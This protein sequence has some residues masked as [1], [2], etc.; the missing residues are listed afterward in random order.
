MNAWKVNFRLAARK[1]MLFCVAAVLVFPWP[2]SQAQTQTLFSAGITNNI[3]PVD[4]MLVLRLANARNLDIQIA[5]RRIGEAQAN[6]E[7][8][9]ERFF[10]WLAPGAV[11]QRHGDLAQNVDGT[12]IDA[13]KQLYTLGGALTAQ[14]ELGDA[15]YSSL[16]AKQR[17][18]AADHGLDSQR[19]DSV[20]SAAQGYYELVKASA[21]VE[22][23]REALNISEDYQQQLHD[24]VDTGIAFKGDELRVQVQTER[25]QIVLQQTLEQ[26]RVAAARLAEVL[27]LDANVELVPQ[28]ADLVP[29]ALVET[30]ATLEALTRQALMARPELKQDR[31]LVAA[32]HEE[33]NSALYG[34]LIPSLN[35]QAF[36]GGLGGGQNGSTGNFGGTED[37]YFGLGWRIGPGGLF[38]FGRIHASKARLEIS[39]LNAAKT[40]DQVVR[41]VVEYYT[42]AASLRGQLGITRQNVATASETL[43]LTSAR[44][45]YGVGIVL[46]N[47]QSQQ[48][49][50]RANSDYVSTLAEYDKAQYG[51]SRA[52]GDLAGIGE[53]LPNS[54]P[55]K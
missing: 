42:R 47:I 6:Q 31:A 1:A 4:L 40:R 34:P 7:S 10:P 14:V 20:L 36:G 32:A 37:Y 30:N 33:K 50:A 15:I 18:K 27:H 8:A 53:A 28:I 41:E 38:D 22:V 5:H 13:N 24:A 44:R 35:A 2:E 12:I 17:V 3:Y 46:E 48:E 54:P 16:A 51:L 39:T 26:Q 9:M 11:Y 43:R 45:E 49:L 23:V 25:Y 21:L 29:L 19:Q 52:I 55:F